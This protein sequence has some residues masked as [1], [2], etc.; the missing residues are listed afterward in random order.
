MLTL[1][2]IFIDRTNGDW[3]TIAEALPES[4]H[5]LNDLV[6]SEEMIVRVLAV[7]EFGPSEPTEET[8]IPSRAGNCS[9]G[10]LV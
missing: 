10:D 4:S 8:T 5:T 3:S 6:P 2:Y 7:N 9:H 1:L